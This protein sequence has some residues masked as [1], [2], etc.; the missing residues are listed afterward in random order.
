MYDQEMEQKPLEEVEQVE[1]FMEHISTKDLYGIQ[2]SVMQEVQSRARA[3]ATNLEV[4]RGVIEMLQIKC[5]Q[6]AIEKE[7]EK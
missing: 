7:E 3:N 5:D 4:G 6:L 2:A 1:M